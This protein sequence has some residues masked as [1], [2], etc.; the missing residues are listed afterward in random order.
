[1]ITR[2][3][4]F[5]NRIVTARLMGDEGIGLYMM[6]MPTLLLVMALTQMGLTVAIAK[7]V[8]EADAVGDTHK[9]KKIIVVSLTITSIL[10]VIFTFGMIIATPFIATY[11][12]T[13]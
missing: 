11:L 4:G 5:I 2:F 7:R 8:S 10:S 9:I 3:L 1:I 13:D 12:L 6:A